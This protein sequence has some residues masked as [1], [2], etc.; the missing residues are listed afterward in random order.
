VKTEKCDALY[1]HQYTPLDFKK[2]K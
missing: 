2:I 1:F